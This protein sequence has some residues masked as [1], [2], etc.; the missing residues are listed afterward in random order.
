MEFW[1][2]SEISSSDIFAPY[3]VF[4]SDRGFSRSKQKAGEVLIAVDSSLKSVRRSDIETVQGPIWVEVN[5]G[6]RENFLDESFYVPPNI[7][8][9]L[10][11]KVITSIESVIFLHSKHR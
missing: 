2:C 5:L 9:V 4:R 8:P 6:R 3:N 1:L 10:L 7:S 11:D